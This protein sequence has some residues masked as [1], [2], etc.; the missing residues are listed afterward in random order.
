MTPFRVF[1]GGLAIAAGALVA[2][3]APV[4]VTTFTE[5]GVDVAAYRTFAWER[6]D[7]GVRGDPRLDNNAFF[8]DSV[9]DAI[10]RQLRLRGYEPD[11]VHPD[12]YVHYHASARQKVYVSGQERST[13]RCRDCSVEVYDEGTLLVDLTDARTGRLVWRGVAESG[14]PNDVDNQTRMEET[15]E[16]VVDR[17]FARLPRRS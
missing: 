14:L 2:A 6:I 16:R 8:H 9:R 15:I 11:G 3:C 17:I 12:A 10:E 4:T 7:A 5:R 13:E 1:A